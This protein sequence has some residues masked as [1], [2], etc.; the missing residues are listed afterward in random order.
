MTY[1]LVQIIVFQL[2]FLV[3]YDLFLRKETFFKWNRVYLL[4]TL[5]LSFVL[6]FIS[7]AT[8]RENIPSEYIIQLPAIVIEGQSA[9]AA[10][11]E[12]F[13]WFKLLSLVWV[14][15][16]FIAAVVFALK[17]RRIISLKKQGELVKGREFNLIRLTGTDKAFTFFR[18]IFIGDQLSA[19]QS[20]SILLHE[21]I[22]V[23]EGHSWDLMIMEAIRV[24]LWFNPLVYLYQKRMVE[25]QEF[26]ADALVARQQDRSHYYE[27]LLNAVF[28]TEKISFINTFFNHSLI[29][30]RIVMLQ[31]SKSKKVFMLKY[32][33]LI[34]L[35]AAM[36]VYTSCTQ[37]TAVK[38][39]P[40]VADMVSQLISAIEE[41]GELS[42]EDRKRLVEV[43]N[44]GQVDL[45]FTDENGNVVA[46]K[47][48]TKA[49]NTFFYR[50][51][52]SIMDID[53][54]PVFPG[55][56]NLD[57]DA[58]RKCFMVKMTELI[59]NN[60]D[61]EAVKAAGINTDQRMAVSFTVTKTGEVVVN[62]IKADHP[63]LEKQISNAMSK[64]PNMTP[65]EHEGETVA[66]QL[67]L[68]ILY[69]LAD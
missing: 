41:K 36:V 68:P 43:L 7:L 27:Q 1:Y 60:F 53:Q 21:R 14:A 49:E 35:L 57:N 32:L 39:E 22:H 34:P 10:A 69:Q 54:V 30:K 58:A 62:G 48:R 56:E 50:D 2:L 46:G 67:G 26:T 5:G 16:L 64:V 47:L 28:G 61:V 33:L 11:A 63:E 40:P 25:L 52:K 51:S 45:H 44:D 24:V 15:G 9:T 66:V 3:C 20:E 23:A 55:C 17:L 6:P 12:N 42:V 4:A 18:N 8:I 31:R 38:E 59:I 13:D 37:E 19:S 65:G 29:K